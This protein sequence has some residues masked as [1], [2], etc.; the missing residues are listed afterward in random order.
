MVD[1]MKYLSENT[2]INKR[3]LLRC[4]FNVP[5]KDG[6]ITDNSKIIRSLDTINYLLDNGN[7]V[8]LLSH[9]G[10]VK[11]EE[12]KK[13]NSLY[14][15]YDELRKY[16]DIDFIEDPLKLESINNSLKRCFLIENTRF[17]DLPEK[18]ESTNDIELAKYWSNF[19]DAF[20][21]DAFGSLHRA[22]ASTAGISKYLPTYLGFL[23]EEEIKK[24]ECLIDNKD[25]P[26]VVIM[27]GAKLDDKI[28][29]I[30]SILTKCDKL[31]LT[32][33]ILNTFLKVTGKNVGKSLVSDDETILQCVKVIL[34]NYKNKIYFTDKF[35]VRRNDDVIE[36]TMNEICDD[37]IVYDN[38]I[39]IKDLLGDAKI[40]FFN[41]TCGKY[42]DQVYSRGTKQLLEDLKISSCKVIVG[43]GDAVS[44][45]NKLGYDNC[46]DYLSSGGGATLE[47]VSYGKLKALEWIKD[48]G[49]D[50]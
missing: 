11:K 32:G 13:E 30:E 33:G 17:T 9:F 36:V 35:V 24:L 37:D 22:H 25:H 10:R 1:S 21:L 5:I 4:D 50:N 49:V 43:G 16:F 19:A 26:F 48:N 15:V 20:V 12:D 27:G 18:R 44:A 29:I 45:V 47:Y 34:D 38:L 3:V 40:V 7:R 8:F 14:T 42:E 41:G 31:V 39:N 23:V 6:G 2:L 46:F 28:K